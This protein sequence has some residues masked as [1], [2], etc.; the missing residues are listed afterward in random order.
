MSCISVAISPFDGHY[1]VVYL[2]D[3]EQVQ[4]RSSEGMTLA[5]LALDHDG[6]GLRVDMSAA[7]MMTVGITATPVMKVRISTYCGVVGET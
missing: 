3:S 7:P 5:T 6:Y 4:L 1:A 2:R